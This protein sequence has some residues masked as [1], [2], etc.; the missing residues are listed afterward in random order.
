M[1]SPPSP[2]IQAHA[3]LIVG[4]LVVVLK[5]TSLGL[6]IGFEELLRRGQI[7]I[8]SLNNPIQMFLLIGMLFII[9]NFSLSKAAEALERRLSTSRRKPQI[10]RRRFQAN[11][12]S[13]TYTTDN[14]ARRCLLAKQHGLKSRHTMARLAVRTRW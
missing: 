8:Q 12:V 7:A 11:Q 2:G 10:H 9:I 6:I 3:A 5:D 1:V 4:Q 13:K 14:G